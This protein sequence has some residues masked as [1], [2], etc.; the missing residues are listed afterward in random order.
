MKDNERPEPPLLGSETETLLGYLDFLRATIDW[1]TTGLTTD[2]LHAQPL[3]SRMSL[4]GLLKHLAFVED[5]WFG[6][7]LA[8]QPAS[9][10]WASV[11]WTAHPDWEWETA[12]EDSAEEL[13]DF[14]QASVTASKRLWDQLNSSQPLELDAAVQHPYGGESISVRW[15]LTH[16]VEEYGRHCGHADLLREEID[17]EVG[18]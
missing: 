2:Q 6:R 3:K 7:A 14:W 16:M 12:L 8:S 5:C 1:K 9:E 15:V 13:R 11:D 4:G 18:E 10:P 17:G